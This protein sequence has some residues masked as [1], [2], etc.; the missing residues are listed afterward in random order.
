MSNQRPISPP[1]YILIRTT[2][3][4]EDGGREARRRRARAVLLGRSCDYR[5]RCEIRIAA[6]LVACVCP[7]PYGTDDAAVDTPR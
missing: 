2:A 4:Q 6:G 3:N 1:R 5:S 7:L